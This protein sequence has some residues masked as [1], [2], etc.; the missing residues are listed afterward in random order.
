[1]KL[2]V[3][4]IKSAKSEKELLE[5]LGSELERLVPVNLHND[6]DSLVA[7]MKSLSP[8][9]RAMAAT[10][11]LDVSMALDDLGWHFANFHHK[12][13]CKET[14]RGLHTLEATEAAEVFD[15]AYQITLPYWH[16]IGKMLKQD[17]GTFSQW[18]NESPLDK[19]LGPLNNKMWEICNRLD[20]RSLMQYWLEYARRYPDRVVMK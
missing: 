19:A 5:R 13:Y 16:D 6:L 8:G 4:K 3:A 2:T 20:K 14:S 15:R 12:P 1:M 10:F 17:F 9:L 7:K 11:K 18:Y